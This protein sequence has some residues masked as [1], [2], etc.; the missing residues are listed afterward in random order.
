MKLPN[1][2]RNLSSHGLT[3]KAL[4]ILISATDIDINTTKHPGNHQQLFSQ[5]IKC[6]TIC[7]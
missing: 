4:Q 6:Y 7:H 2:Q 5:G 3:K 1:M